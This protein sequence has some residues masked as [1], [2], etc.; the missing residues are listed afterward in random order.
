MIYGETH[1]KWRLDVRSFFRSLTV[2]PRRIVPPQVNQEEGKEGN[3]RS[4]EVEAIAV[5]LGSEKTKVAIFI[6]SST[7]GTRGKPFN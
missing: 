6:I 7:W 3:N 2:K 4:V 5:V 1:S